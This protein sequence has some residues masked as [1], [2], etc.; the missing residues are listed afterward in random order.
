MFDKDR[1]TGLWV[2]SDEKPVGIAESLTK[3]EE[4]L[5]S[6]M[7]DP[8]YG[9]CYIFVTGTKNV[10]SEN[11]FIGGRIVSPDGIDM[12][13][14]EDFFKDKDY[15]LK[16]FNSKIKIHSG[17]VHYSDIAVPIL[18][19]VFDALRESQIN[20]VARVTGIPNIKD[21]VG[22]Y[23]DGKLFTDLEDKHGL[24]KLLK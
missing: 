18:R 1:L 23:I 22:Y 5:V 7:V 4:I 10:S 19:P 14:Y 21:L 13:F 6:N 15:K 11:S 24:T 12:P 8:L 17:V 3:K 9:K 16:E 20:F 2:Y